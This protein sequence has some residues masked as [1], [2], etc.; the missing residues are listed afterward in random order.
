MCASHI[1]FRNSRVLSAQKVHP[2]SN[3]AFVCQNRSRCRNKNSERKQG[4]PLLLLLMGSPHATTAQSWC[5]DEHFFRAASFPRSGGPTQKSRLDWILK[6]LSPLR[7]Y[8]GPF[9]LDLFIRRTWMA[10]VCE[11]RRGHSPLRS[12]RQ[13]FSPHDYRCGKGMLA[14]EKGF[15]YLC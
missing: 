1:C 2:F 14:Q 12:Q 5:N 3:Q 7:T 9:T 11:N 10:Y 15:F 8:E 6:C 13:Q 4:S